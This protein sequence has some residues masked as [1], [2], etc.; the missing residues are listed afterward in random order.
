MKDTPAPAP[1][2][3]PLAGITLRLLGPAD[4]A[5]IEQAHDDVFDG[6]A[7]AALIDDF[8]DDPRALLAGAIDTTR[9]IGRGQLIGM[10]SAHCYNH[11]DKPRQLFIDEVGVAGSHRRRGIGNALVQLL[12]AQGRALG[13]VEAWVA[14]EEDNREARALYAAAG[15]AAESDRVVVYVFD[16]APAAQR[17]D[18]T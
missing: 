2:P 10:A 8:F 5:L 18:D 15:G 6:P 17:P 7:H 11:P 16:L 3:A 9:D 13:C 1:Q 12:L 4:Y 14:T